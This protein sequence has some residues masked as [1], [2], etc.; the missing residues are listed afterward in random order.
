[1]GEEEGRKEEKGK[2]RERSTKL[3]LTFK[4]SLIKLSTPVKA[5][6]KFEAVGMAFKSVSKCKTLCQ[7]YKMYSS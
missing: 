7:A 4:N 1:M 6:K 5:A 3:S 2:R